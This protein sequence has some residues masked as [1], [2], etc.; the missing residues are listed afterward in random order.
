MATSLGFLIIILALILHPIN[1]F[2][3]PTIEPGWKRPQPELLVAAK[4]ADGAKPQSWLPA[5]GDGSV[6]WKVM[7][8]REGTKAALSDD[9]PLYAAIEDAN[10]GCQWTYDADEDWFTEP[11]PKSANTIMSQWE[12]PQNRDTFLFILDPASGILFDV[13]QD[14]RPGYKPQIYAAIKAWNTATNDTPDS[15]TL[16]YIYRNIVSQDDQ[17]NMAYLLRQAGWDQWVELSSRKSGAK[18]DVLL[19]LEASELLYRF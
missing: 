13:D 18:F 9:D 16:R 12:Y 4:R 15:K 1:P 7:K 19:G 5:A 17:D 11:G 6:R 10:E 3:Q 2:A 14:R 8:S